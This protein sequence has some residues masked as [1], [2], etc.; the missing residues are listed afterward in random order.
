MT[1]V[2][3]LAQSRGQ[4]TCR[5]SFCIGAYEKPFTLILQRTAVSGQARL[6]LDSSA[7]SEDSSEDNSENSSEEI[8]AGAYIYRGIATNRDSL[9]DSEIVH[10]PI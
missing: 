3:F 5:T 2:G 1:N 9:S 7:D 10:W 6:D 4:D 8:N